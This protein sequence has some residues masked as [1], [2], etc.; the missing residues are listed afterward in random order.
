MICSQAGH[1]KFLA[2][3]SDRGADM[4]LVNSFGQSAAHAASQAGQLK[5]LQLLAKR[6][7]KLS[8]RDWVTGKT[9]LDHARTFKQLDCIDFLLTNKATGQLVENL[10]PMSKAEKVCMTA[11]FCVFV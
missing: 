4:S 5:C 7:A 8:T 1:V 10:I 2:L 11:S 3:L 6:G 9:P